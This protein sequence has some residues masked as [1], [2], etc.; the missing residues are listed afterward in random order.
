MSK[1][2]FLCFIIVS[3]WGAE[4]NGQITSESAALQVARTFLQRV[5]PEISPGDLS[6]LS[7]RRVVG[8]RLDLTVARWSVGGGDRIVSL[9]EET[10]AI[11]AY[12]NSKLYSAVNGPDGLRL[13]KSGPPFYRNEADLITRAKRKLEAIGWAFGPDVSYGHRPIPV[14]DAHGNIGKVIICL[15]FHDR[16]NGYSTLGAGN[17]AIFSLD[18]LT[19]EIVELQRFIG[20]TY[21]PPTVNITSEQAVQA[22]REVIDVGPSPTVL[23]PAYQCLIEWG[24]LSERGRALYRS[25]TMP[26]GYWVHGLK[27]DAVVASDTGEILNHYP[28]ATGGEEPDSAANA[29]TTQLPTGRVASDNESAANA[30]SAPGKGTRGNPMTVVLSSAAALLVVAGAIWAFRHA[31]R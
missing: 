10:G 14:P 26:L 24:P 5:E 19:G 27:E 29:A 9:D 23:G 4:V 18:S 7:A 17:R 1:C 16:P 11:K 13:P 2:R 15:K 30:G 20:Y 22:A 12:S 8:H 6:L 31:H 25:K 3:C 21:A 28:N